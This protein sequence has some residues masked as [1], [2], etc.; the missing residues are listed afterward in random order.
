M[1]NLDTVWSWVI[2]ATPALPLAKRPCVCPRAGLD[3]NG[4]ERIFCIHQG[5]IPGPFSS[6][7]AAAS[8]YFGPQRITGVDQNVWRLRRKIF[9]SKIDPAYNDIG[10]RDTPFVASD[11]LWNQLIP[12]GLTVTLYSDTSSNEDNQFR[13]HIH[14]PKR[15]FPQVSIE[16]RLIRSGCC[17]LSKV[18]FYKIE[19]STL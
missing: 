17:P 10:L 1:L 15:D 12:H 13:N 11:I 3:R 9:I 18:K 7:R 4:E 8:D 6:Q 19:K 2:K 14:Q 16:T 5:V